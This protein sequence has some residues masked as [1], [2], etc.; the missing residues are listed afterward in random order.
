M[1]RTLYLWRSSEKRA[2]V[3]LHL[4]ALAG[5]DG[6]YVVLVV[7]L[8]RRRLQSTCASSS[9]RTRMERTLYLWRSSEKRAA[10]DLHLVVLAGRDGAYVVLVVQLLGKGFYKLRRVLYRS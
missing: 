3:D 4:V 6:A 5:R 2:A 7:Q 8:R 1:E 9:L 10:V